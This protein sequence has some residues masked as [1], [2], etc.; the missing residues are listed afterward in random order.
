M[1]THK[2]YVQD[3]MIADIRNVGPEYFVM[4]LQSKEA[5]PPMFPGQFAQVRVDRANNVLLRRTFSIHDVDE[6]NRIIKLLIKKVGTGTNALS[7][8]KQFDKVNMIYPLGNHFSIPQG[9]KILLVGGGCGV[10]PLLFLAKTLNQHH[11]RPI[12]LM[13]GRDKSQI[14]QVDEYVKYG[15][16]LIMTED[17][18][19]GDKGLVIDHDVFKKMD[20]DKIYTCGP[21]PMM[22]AVYERAQQQQIPCEFSLENTMAC[23]IGACLC[24]VT[25]R[26]EGNVCVCTE[27]PVF[28]KWE[29]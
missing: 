6:K 19:M 2:K 11:I 3:F 28:D 25:K 26:E 5:L 9:N 8:L 23:G 17:G 16:V 24:C 10:A 12:I 20:F 27:G 22:K 4:E 21:N 18:S 29:E 14:I 1:K 7:L 13:G 15:Q